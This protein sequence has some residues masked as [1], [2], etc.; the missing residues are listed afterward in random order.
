MVSAALASM[1]LLAV[2]PV[3]VE[4][5]DCPSGVEVE[6]MLAA[7]LPS[8]PDTARRDVARVKKRALGLRIELLQP[9]G[10][11]IAERSLERQGSCRELAE[12][13]ATTIARWEGDAHPELLRPNADSTPGPSIELPTAQRAHPGAYDAALGGSLSYA[14][15]LAAGAVL[16]LTW[17]PG[18]SGLGV[19]VLGSTD[20]ERTVDLD[21]GRA[22][23]RR[24]TGSAELD[25]RLSGLPL[26]FHGGVALGWLTTRGLDALDVHRTASFSPAATLGTRLAWWMTR[27]LA[28]WLDVSGYTWIRSQKMYADPPAR[29]QEISRWQG[30]ASAG[31]AIG[32]LPPGR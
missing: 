10:G 21:V 1:L 14:G 22:R 27:Q 15:S 18:A 30:V 26:D 11:V 25:W 17:I 29:E 32:S 16:A 7:M 2:S 3:Q 28:L 20:M 6:Q 13:A 19:R 4:S 9:D 5:E 24:W 12:F 8:V 31:L 23:W